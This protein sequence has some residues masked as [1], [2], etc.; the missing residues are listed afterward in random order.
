MNLR[1]CQWCKGPVPVRS[2]VCPRCGTPVTR[3]GTTH[4]AVSQSDDDR[5]E[6]KRRL[7]IIAGSYFLTVLG[8]Y[9]AVEGGEVGQSY[10]LLVGVALALFGVCGLVSAEKSPA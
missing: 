6:T 1:A 4:N 8:I 5:E 10:L 7:G 3:D 2:E 9:A